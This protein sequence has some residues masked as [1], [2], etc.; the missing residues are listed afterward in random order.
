MGDKLKINTKITEMI[1]YGVPYRDIAKQFGITVYG[2][3]E[4]MRKHNIV[5]DKILSKRN[6]NIIYELKSAPAKVVAERYNLTT[7]RVMK[8]AKM[9]KKKKRAGKYYTTKWAFSNWIGSDYNNHIYIKE[10]GR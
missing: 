6:N 1:Y 9:S 3:V 5:R 8:I 2:L 10:K 7:E 4:Y